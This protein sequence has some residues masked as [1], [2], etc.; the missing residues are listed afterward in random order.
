V[1]YKTLEIS[2]GVYYAKHFK[3]MI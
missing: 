2:A 1:L 3:I